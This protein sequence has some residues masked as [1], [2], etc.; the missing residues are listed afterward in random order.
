MYACIPENGRGFIEGVCKLDDRSLTF[1]DPPLDSRIDSESHALATL[2]VRFSAR[3]WKRL[4]E[5]PLLALWYIS[6]LL[7]TTAPASASL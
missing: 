6:P 3:L 1:R 4:S 7:D 5:K 2:L